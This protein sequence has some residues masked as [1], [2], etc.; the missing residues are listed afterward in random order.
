[1]C[2]ILK[3]KFLD[4]V[5]QFD[6]EDERI[7]LKI[8]H[9]FHVVD[10]MEYLVKSLRLSAYECRV[11]YAIALFHDIGRFLQIERYHTFIDADSVDHALLGCQIIRENHF[12]DEEEELIVCAIRNHNKLKVESGLDNLHL[13]MCYLIRDADKCDIFRVFAMQEYPVLFGFDQSVIENSL[14]SDAIKHC[15]MH[16]C[17]VR[18]E[19][20]QPGIDFCLTFLGFFYDLNFDVSIEYLMKDRLFLIPFSGFNFVHEKTRQ[21]VDEILNELNLFLEKRLL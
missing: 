4:Y 8:E 9:S 10:V 3:N 18:K 14:V 5:S 11:A 21:D 13:R 1:M 17:C 12:F 7:R 16:H 19:D 15:L 20:R 2:D 6:L